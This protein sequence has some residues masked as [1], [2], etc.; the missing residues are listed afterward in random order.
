[1]NYS[2]IISWAEDEYVVLND[3]FYY[4]AFLY[5]QEEFI[6]MINQGIKSSILL[7]KNAQGN[8]GYFYVSLSKREKGE[9]SVYNRL[10]HLPMFIITNKISAIKTRNFRRY[11]HYSSWIINSPFPFRES[12]YDD[13]YQKFLKVSAKNILA[14]QYNIYP[15]HQHSDIENRLLILKSMIEDLN[16]Q[17]ICLPIFDGSTFK[18][19]NQEKILSLKI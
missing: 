5:K 8:N 3:A 10:N 13:E 14:I 15:Y 6:N 18:K 12:E 2:D 16:S 7:G 1:M 19:I 9:F 4:H 11:G 17:K